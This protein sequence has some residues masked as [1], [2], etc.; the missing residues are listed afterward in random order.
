[1]SFAWDDSHSRAH[2]MQPVST[3]AK[4][5]LPK[6]LAA[7]ERLSTVCTPPTTISKEALERQKKSERARAARVM[8]ILG[9]CTGCGGDAVHRHHPDGAASSSQIFGLCEA[10]HAFVHKGGRRRP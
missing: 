8:P 3:I 9:I 2:D 7:S 10:C 1:M 6:L 5:L 4:R